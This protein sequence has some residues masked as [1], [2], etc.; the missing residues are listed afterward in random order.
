MHIQS[1]HGSS[2]KHL[3]QASGSIYLLVIKTHLMLPADAAYQD[4]L[5][6][7]IKIP[8][9]MGLSSRFSVKNFRLLGKSKPLSRIN[10]FPPIF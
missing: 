1:T 3:R 8:L 7:K 5:P 4:E 10:E 6:H 2:W 9:Q